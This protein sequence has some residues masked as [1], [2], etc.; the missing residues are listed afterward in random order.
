MNYLDKKKEA[1]KISDL[2]TS[3]PAQLTWR[4]QEVIDEQMEHERHME[5]TAKGLNE[6]GKK[7]R[8]VRRE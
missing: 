7:F 6:E 3:G 8:T 5:A 4:E 1:I 2:Q